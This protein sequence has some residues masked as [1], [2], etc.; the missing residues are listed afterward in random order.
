MTKA[1]KITKTK[2]T[3]I[4]IEIKTNRNDK[5]TNYENLNKTNQNIYFFP[6][7]IKMTKA[8]KITKTELQVK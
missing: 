7:I 4:Q 5:N 1:L 6:K 2:L 8:H 3:S